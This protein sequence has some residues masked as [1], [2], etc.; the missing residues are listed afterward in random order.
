MIVEFLKYL[1]T[2]LRKSE[3]NAED[4]DCKNGK[5]KMK[6]ESKP[7]R[8]ILTV[9]E[10]PDSGDLFIA[11]PQELLENVGWKEGD[12]IEWTQ[13]NNGSWILSKKSV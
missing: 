1:P 8:E 7:G 9:E 11:L 13:D 6:Q 2:F 3:K 5:K 4:Y 10:D 12:T